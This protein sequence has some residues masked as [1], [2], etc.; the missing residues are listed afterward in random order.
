MIN[1]GQHLHTETVKHI[2]SLR[3]RNSGP[4]IDYAEKHTFQDQSAIFN[5]LPLNTRQIIDKNVFSREAR[6][7]Y[8]DKAL[9]RALS[10]LGFLHIHILSLFLKSM[11]TAILS[12]MPSLTQF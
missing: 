2:R 4:K 11:L 5:D 10:L 3:S 9:A 12:A 1:F 6:G 8:K 7:F